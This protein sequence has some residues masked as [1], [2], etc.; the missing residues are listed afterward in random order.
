[1]HSK[2]DP[3]IPPYCFGDYKVKFCQNSI[4]KRMLIKRQLRCKAR[5]TN[6]WC[7]WTWRCLCCQPISSW[8]F[9]IQLDH[10][11]G[12]WNQ[13]PKLRYVRNAIRC[14]FSSENLILDWHGPF[15]VNNNSINSL[16]MKSQN[17]FCL[18]LQFKY[19]RDQLKGNTTL[20][21]GKTIVH[22]V[23]SI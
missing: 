23:E 15:V 9:Q 4:A 12:Q 2:T 17:D 16:Q 5:L 1:M 11:M 7:L 10:R 18:I 21:T 8:G 3:Y 19:L 13:Q 14:N 20:H 6:A 22:L